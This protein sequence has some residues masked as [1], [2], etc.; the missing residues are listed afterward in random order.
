MTPLIHPTAT[1][2]TSA[3][4]APGA[5]VGAHS[6]IGADSRLD[7][8]AVVGPYTELG[9]RN[10]VH[11]FAVVGGP[12]QE[13]RTPADGAFRLRCGDDN[14]FREGVTVSRGTEKGGGE[15]LIGDHVLLMARSHVAHDC[16]LG[17]HITLANGVSLGGH[18]VVGD[19]VTFGGHAAVHQFCRI[20]TLAFIAANGMISRDVP[21]YCL[22]AGDRATLRGLNVTGLRRA[23]FEPDTRR[24]LARAYR[25][26]L[27][28]PRR[29]GADLD[30][31]RNAPCEAVRILAAFLQTSERGVMRALRSVPRDR[32]QPC[33]RGV[34]SEASGTFS[35][36]ETEALRDREG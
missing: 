17:D 35:T 29:L 34:K 24:V 25:A 22:A 6:V 7:T 12:A 1:I 13:R 11:A 36:P 10:H 8:Y 9:A 14:I 28:A 3:S 18:V 4:I 15:T 32:W 30:A 33:D 21:P 20:G 16:R 27:R 2:S 19:R 26:L 31:A 5:V 23:G